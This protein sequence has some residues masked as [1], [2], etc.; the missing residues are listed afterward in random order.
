MLESRRG[1]GLT[2]LL[3]AITVLGVGLLAVTGLVSASGE[4]TRDAARRTERVIVAAQALEAA[5]VLPFDSLISTIDTAA[6]PR[7]YILDLSVGVLSPSLKRLDLTVADSAVRL[8]LRLTTFVARP[9][10]L[11]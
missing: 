3:V 5:A 2:E 4:R 8:P 6:G 11:P 7:P 10:W 9:A 1:F